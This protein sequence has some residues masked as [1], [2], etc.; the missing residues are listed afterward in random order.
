AI[1]S[2]PIAGKFLYTP[3]GGG[4]APAECQD[5]VFVLECSPRRPEHDGMLGSQFGQRLS[6]EQIFTYCA[7]SGTRHRLTRREGP[8]KGPASSDQYFFEKS[9]NVF[10]SHHS[11]QFML[12]SVNMLPSENMLPSDMMMSTDIQVAFGKNVAFGYIVLFSGPLTFQM[13]YAPGRCRDVRRKS[14]PGRVHFRPLPQA[15]VGIP[16]LQMVSLSFGIWVGSRQLGIRAI[17]LISCRLRTSLT[18][19]LFLVTV[20]MGPK[21]GGVRRG[22]RQSSRV[23]GQVPQPEQEEI[24]RQAPAPEPVG[25]T[26]VGGPSGAAP[27]MTT[28]PV[29]P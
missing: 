29:D 12:P 28:V 17:G 6:L 15:D 8:S 16:S 9:L 18:E 11:T 14:P 20:S 7:L 3:T 5:W 23:R 4:G 26:F 27:A 22:T 21:R 13:F 19:H 25:G 1:L 24:P 2:F 10:F